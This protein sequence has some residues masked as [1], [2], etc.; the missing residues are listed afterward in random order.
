[1][2]RSAKTL[3]VLL[4]TL[5]FG[6]LAAAQTRG[7]SQTT[8]PL[9][10]QDGHGNPISGLAPSDI[11]AKVQ[12]RSVRVLSITPDARPH[13]VVL[14]V[15]ATR[16]FEAK[17]GEPPRWPWEMALAKH[18]FDENSPHSKIAL[19]LYS[20]QLY[21]V[22]D[23]SQGNPAVKDKLT[24][25]I[26]STNSL[27][28]EPNHSRSLR[29]AIADALRLLDH[30][31]SAD[32]IYVLTDAQW[33]VPL[34]SSKLASR[35]TESGV[36]LFGVLFQSE[37]G[38]RNKAAEEIMGGEQL[39]QLAQQSGGAILTKADWRDGRVILSANSGETGTNQATLVRLYQPILHNDLLALE[40]P[41]TAAGPL[42]LRLSAAGQQRWKNAKILYPQSTPICAPTVARS[43]P[44]RT[45]N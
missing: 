8:L 7:C 1:M 42:E 14:V 6:Q 25:A 23:F 20:P 31:D 27:K 18:F 15:D 40:S 5:S 44:S 2:R 12:R 29:D 9:Y 33:S 37:S 24:Q 39:S 13:R 17:D 34:N 38:F 41:A 21:D 32:V 30:S 10:A 22:V 16:S 19:L 28:I 35:L 4:S 3:A 45:A 36:R 26:A 43:D 11:E